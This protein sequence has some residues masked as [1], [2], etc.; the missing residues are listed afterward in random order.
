MNEEIIKIAAKE[1]EITEKQV[2]QI[3][4]LDESK[5]IESSWSNM[6]PALD[7]ANVVLD[8]V[9]AMQGEVD[10]AFT[11]L[12][13]AF[14]NLR[15][16]PNKDLLQ[17]LINKA[18]SLNAANYSAKTWAAVAEALNEAKVVLEDPEA[19][20]DQVDNVKDV[21]TKAIAG[22]QVEIK[23][24]SNPVKAGDSTASVA[25]GDTT[26][27]NAALGVAASLSMLAYLSKKKK[28]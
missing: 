8:D 20:Q 12:V 13:K 24:T 18:N 2:D 5:Y 23:E 17:E 1:L 3:N 14:L 6:L 22:L 10:E 21:L 26:N 25:T 19:T 11:E 16:K 27:L 9:N 7:K 15:L 28:K 4:G